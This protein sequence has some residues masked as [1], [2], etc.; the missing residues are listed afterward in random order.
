MSDKKKPLITVAVPAYNHEAWVEE[1]ILS[2]V[3]QTYGYE[4]IQLIV[5]DDCST[6]KTPVILKE[7]ANKYKFELIR[8]E[9]NLGICLTINNMIERSKGNYIAGIASDDIMLLD[10]IE[11]QVDILTKNPEIDI[12]AGNSINIDSNGNEIGSKAQNYDDSLTSYSFEDIFL[13]LKPGFPAGSAIIKKEL[14]DRIGVYDPNYRMEDLYFWLKAA[15]NN[16]TIVKCNR[17]FLYY[18]IH[19][20]SISA[21]NELMFQESIKIRTIYKEHPKYSE[22]IQFLNLSK[23]SNLVFISKRKVIQIL[24]KSPI[25][26]THKKGIKIIIMLILPKYLLKRKFSEKYHRNATN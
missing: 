3:N 5:T 25:I 17:P 21:N 23:L 4:N 15:H 19:Q 9:Q 11:K 8:N 24:I 7:L 10:R 2:I 12:L 18:R 22:A 6:D 26:L 1:T 14:F 13:R 20:N 16:A